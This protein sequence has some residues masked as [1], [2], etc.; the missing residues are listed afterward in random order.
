MNEPGA[1]TLT[2]MPTKNV[3]V[4]AFDC[5]GVLFDTEKAN[6]V[7]YNRLLAHFNRP[8]MTDEQFVFAHMHTLNE[9]LAHLFPDEKSLAAVH[10]Y[11]KGLDYRWYLKELTVEPHLVALLEKIRPKIKTAI[12]TNRTDTMTRLL[13]EFG[14]DG[15]FDLVVTSSDVERPKPHP[16]ALLKILDHFG[17]EPRQAIYVGDSA[18]D[19]MAARAAGIPLVAYRN[20]QL[21]SSCHIDSFE[22]LEALLMA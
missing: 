16:E 13:V 14:L 18:L 1:C 22:E 11:R 19:E 7:Y 12:A 15:Y 6:R 8:E 21:S 5:D 2:T 9:A 10:D 4:V 3:K 17:I 20:R